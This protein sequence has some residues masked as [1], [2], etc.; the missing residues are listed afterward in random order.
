M[1]I[2][3]T[4]TIILKKAIE[5]GLRGRRGF[6]RI[7]NIEKILIRD[8]PSNLC[9]PCAISSIAFFAT[10]LI[11]SSLFAQERIVTITGSIADSA[12]GERIP[13]ASVMVAGTSIG[14]V[15]DVNGY[16][17]LRNVTLH[18]TKLRAAAVGYK[19][20]EF[21]VEY[22]GK[23]SI[24][25]N[26]KLPES[27]RTL[28]AVE[29]FGKTLNG[30]AGIPGSTV[31]TS[32]QLQN[33]V[34]IFKNDV[35]QYITQ[36]P[37][38]VTV[39]GISSQYYV[40]G[41]GP[42]ENLVLVDNMQIYN[43]SHAFGLFSFVDP[44]IVKVANFSV[45]GFQAQY[46]GR[47]SSVFDIQTIDGDKNEFQAKD[48]LDLLSS[49]ALITGPLFG[50]GHSSFVAFY[51]RPLFQNVLQKFYSLALPF[52]Y[53]DGFAKADMDFAGDGHLSAEF[54]T[55]ADQILQ[56]SPI[57]PDFKWSNNSGAVS[58]GFLT[59]DQFDLKFSISYSKYHAEQ[60]PKQS[61]TLGYQLDDISNLSLY[62][63]VVSYTSSRDQLD[64]GLNFSFQNYNY[65]FA[66]KYGS[67]V[68]DSVTEV[69]PQL[70]AKYDFN[71]QGRFS[72]EAGLRTDLQRAFQYLSN[73][74]GG[75]ITEPRLTVSYMLSDQVTIYADYGIYHQR[76]M[77]LNDENLVFTPF[78]VLAPVP[79]S[80]SDEESSQY[81]LGCKLE[82]NNL[83][84]VKVEVYY[85]D[86][87]H[88]E[89]VN[90]NKVYDYESDYVLGIGKAY[91]A[92]VSFRYD[93]GENLYL[94]AGYSYSTTTRTFNGATYYPRYDLRNQINLS[95]GLELAR[96]LWI[97]ARLKLTSG[98][99]YTP[100]TGYFG[101][102]P[103]NP[104]N[105]PSYTKQAL[106][107]QAL[108][109]SVNTARLPGY[110]SLD[111]SASYDWN[112][113]WSQ[114]SIHGTLINLLDNKNVFYINN[115]TGEVVYQL[116]TVFNLSVEWD[117]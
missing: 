57:E 30:A 112:F 73:T 21:S 10:I 8:N 35:V 63:D 107:S 1:K 61:E 31:I 16:F 79:D 14:T 109:G 24:T 96:N 44:M 71:P 64:V 54:L 60:L 2:F 25:L 100:I 81:I 102:I 29:V 94:Q 99:P 37:G 75:Y 97:R 84:S 59:G 4:I 56:Q 65:T 103:F 32:S 72:F 40:R 9:Y 18:D 76:L 45:G 48:N 36:L 90:F 66:N 39:S 83:T 43:L 111:I 87:N 92:D 80:S 93:A 68:E 27:P 114:L 6:P 17:I 47:L 55:S 78:D 26:L 117:I 33:S 85:K 62:G 19:E 110:Q 106:Y 28:P 53:Y 12:S 20:K 15:A 67:I 91:G 11:A 70:W 5:H 95:S 69:E 115:I 50:D 23:E 41:G 101:V 89:A 13:Y 104:S 34:G 74:P 58:G 108:F 46:G 7:S 88:L 77:D 105:L 22:N 49:D 51:R 52:N 86:L 42:D 38:V 3:C 116:P 98:L 82:P 113:S